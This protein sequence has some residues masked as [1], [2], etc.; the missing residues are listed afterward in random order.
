[1]QT[2]LIP[3]SDHFYLSCALYRVE[4]PKAVVQII[5]GASEYKGRYE[6]V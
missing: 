6:K 3:A 2:L 1:M 5:H 4:N